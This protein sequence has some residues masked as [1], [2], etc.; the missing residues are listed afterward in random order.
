VANATNKHRT[1]KPAKDE[2]NATGDSGQKIDRPGFDLSGSS[3][4][5]HVGTGLGLGNDAF[6]TPGE[7]RLPGRRPDTKLTIPRWGGPDPAGPA[8]PSQKPAGR[9]T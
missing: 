9:K 7:R 8:K 5:T 3:D 6:D 4:D 2:P 1:K